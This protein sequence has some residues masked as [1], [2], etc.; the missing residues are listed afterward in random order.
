MNTESEWRVKDKTR[1][2]LAIMQALAGDTHI[3]FEGDL[4]DFRLS[5]FGGA[6]DRET[7]CLRRNTLWPKQDFVVIPLEPG[8]ETAILSAIGGQVPKR[9]IHIQI[10]RDGVLQFAAYDS[11]DPEC[12]FWGPALKPEFLESLTVEGVLERL[13]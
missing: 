9:I 11:F 5:G 2:L 6:S 7:T 12:L 4:R 10:E 1:F 13:S 8:T 3:S